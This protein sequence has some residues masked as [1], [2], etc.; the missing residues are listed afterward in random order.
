MKQAPAREAGERPAPK[1]YVPTWTSPGGTY[2]STLEVERFKDHVLRL[3]PTAKLNRLYGCENGQC[4]VIV[5]LGGDN[6]EFLHLTRFGDGRYG[7]ETCKADTLR[8]VLE[9]RK[10]SLEDT[11]RHARARAKLIVLAAEPAAAVPS[12]PDKC[13]ESEDGL[14]DGAWLAGGSCL[15]CGTPFSAGKPP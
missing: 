5:T 8:G 2:P 6:S 13:P 7:A 9:K 15:E 12:D 11:A 4:T 14:H 10:R 3:L 1:P